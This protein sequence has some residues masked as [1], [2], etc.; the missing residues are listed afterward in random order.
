VRHS[1]IGRTV[2]PPTAASLT[3]PT[4]RVLVIQRDGITKDRFTLQ[5][6]AVAVD[7]GCEA[8]T[9]ARPVGVEERRRTNVAEFTDATDQLLPRHH[10][11]SGH[12]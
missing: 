8:T 3:R 6:S 4:C 2:R 7:T 1:A 10:L 9:D 5:R 11:C 12:A